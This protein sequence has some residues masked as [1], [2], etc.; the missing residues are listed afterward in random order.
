MHVVVVMVTKRKMWPSACRLS[1]KTVTV[2]VPYKLENLRI[3]YLAK[4]ANTHAF[5]I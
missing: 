1:N 2:Y 3:Y 4:V 5:G